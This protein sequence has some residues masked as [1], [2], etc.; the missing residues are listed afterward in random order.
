MSL[1][2]DIRYL[3]SRKNK[4]RY[5]GW[6]GY[7]NL[8]DEILFDAFN[9]YFD[10]N[11]AF[12]SKSYISRIVKYSQNNFR[13]V[14]LGGGTLINVDSY[15]EPLNE[16]NYEKKIVFGTGVANSNFWK[17]IDGYNECKEQWVEF[18]DSVDFLGVRGP[19]SAE[20]LESWGVKN[21]VSVIGD[22]ALAFARSAIKTKKKTRT[23]GIN[24]G[25]ARNLLWGQDQNGFL[26]QCKLLVKK[27]ISQEWDITFFP[28]CPGD[29][30]IIDEL[31]ASFSSENVKVIENYLCLE[32]FMQE[33]DEVDIFVGEK[34]HA[35]IISICSLTPT[36]M[37]EYRPKCNDFMRSVNMEQYSVRTDQID[38]GLL[39]E[40]IERLY[41]N[42][43]A[44][45]EQLL[46]E[47]YK[48]RGKLDEAARHVIDIITSK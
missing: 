37:L 18:L 45:Q 39:I 12:Y 46:I 25:D 13:N 14:F 38:I 21:K 28:V 11:V 35:S 43:D 19:M 41:G 3:V 10:K 22:P 7:D 42:A 31:M 4:A 26:S 24:V 30:R 40:M 36:I 17:D 27:L 32:S 8:G 29:K 16:F 2:G 1:T 33:L 34:L 48:Y 9:K 15:L 23:I 6:L 47:T 5:I 20:I 44:V